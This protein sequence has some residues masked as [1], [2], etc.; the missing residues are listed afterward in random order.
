MQNLFQISNPLKKLKEDSS[1]KSYQRK[2]DRKIEFF[3]LFYTVL[4]AK[5]FSVDFFNGYELSIKCCVL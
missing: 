4:C 5:F 1:E 2:S 3:L